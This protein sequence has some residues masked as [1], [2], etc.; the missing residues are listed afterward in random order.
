MCP[1]SCIAYTG[2]FSNLDKCPKCS[3]SRYNQQILEQSKGKKL[4]STQQFHTMPIGSQIQALWRDKTSAENRR[5]HETAAAKILKQI[6][7]SDGDSPEEHDDFFAGSDYICAVQDG[8]NQSDNTVLIFSMDG[9]Q[10]YKTKLSDY[11]MYIWVI[12]DISPDKHYKKKYVIPGCII[13]GPNKPVNINLF[14]FPGLH[15]L[16]AIQKQGFACG[17][18]LK[19]AYLPQGLFSLLQLQMAQE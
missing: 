8:Y 9:A 15:H 16:S 13:P 19:A 1:N 4:V 6:R 3:I 17:I 11:W 7:C 18:H 12:F 2:P 14:L 10:L 5:H